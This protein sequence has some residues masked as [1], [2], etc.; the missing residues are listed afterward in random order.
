MT[1]YENK[2]LIWQKLHVENLFL[3][4]MIFFFLESQAA[5][6]LFL[7]GGLSLVGWP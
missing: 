6:G 7:F 4:L 1:K 3:E 2:C 5:D